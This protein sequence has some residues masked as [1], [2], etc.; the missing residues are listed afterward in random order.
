MNTT[1]GMLYVTS[2]RT[3]QRLDIQFMPKELAT[4]RTANFADIAIVGRN[5]PLHHY[6][7]GD[8]S[9]SFEFDFYSETENR[10][11]VIEKCR[12]LE[13]WSMNDGDTPPEQIRLTF[14]RLFKADEIWIIKKVAVRYSLFSPEHGMLPRQAYA[15]VDFVLDPKFN[16]K[17]SDVKWT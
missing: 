8:N 12:L 16:R 4:D 7:G 3:L 13:S 15:K 2:M 17:T 5:N 14:G 1:Q 6:T 11:D 10:E 9:L